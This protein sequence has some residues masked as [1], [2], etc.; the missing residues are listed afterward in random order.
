MAYALGTTWAGWIQTHSDDWNAIAELS[1][2]K[3]LMSRIAE[4]DESYDFGGPHLYLGVFETLLPP[5]LGGQPEAGRTHFERAVQL[6]GGTHLL[7]KVYFAQQYGRLVFD[8]EL[9]DRLLNEVI[10]ADPRIDGITLL[11]KVA[12]LQAGVLLESSDSY[13]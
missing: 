4:L 6:S 5:A 3:L 7:T 13:F 12:Q 10:A 8:K 11:N 2:V 1:R 9:H